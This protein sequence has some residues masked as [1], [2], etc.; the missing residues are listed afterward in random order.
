MIKFDLIDHDVLLQK[1]QFYRINQSSLNWFGSYLTKPNT[2]VF[3]NSV[4]SDKG[5]IGDRLPRIF[6]YTNVKTELYAD[7]T[8]IYATRPSREEAEIQQQQMRN[9]LTN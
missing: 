2:K 4:I 8:T 7:D 1:L 3:M 5:Y 6:P 9:S